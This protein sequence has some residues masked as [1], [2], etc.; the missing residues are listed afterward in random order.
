[1]TLWTRTVVVGVLAWTCALTVDWT[2]RL[3]AQG[4]TSPRIWQGVFSATQAARGKET[5]NTACVRCHGS[6]LGGTT[7]PALT[8]DRFQT[9]FGREPIEKLFLK[10]RDTMPPNFGTV[11]DDQAKL[12]IVTYIL[13][14]N[15]YPG[16]AA[17]LALGSEDLVG[18][19]VLR[20]GEQASV[21]NFS[22]VQTVGC[23]VRG[24][25]DTWM[26]QK[27]AEPAATRDD[28]PTPEGLAAAAGRRLGTRTFRLLSAGSFSPQVHEGRKME[29]RG[30]VY[31]E[32]ADS[33]LSL[34]SLQM[35][36]ASCDSE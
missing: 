28:V 10:I 23:L 6:E 24:P 33:R 26:L 18:A 27:T 25:N 17:E 21:Q 36:A 9:T 5:F 15:G 11:L 14:T 19:Q 3:D 34:T 20:Q 35:V 29:A 1:M 22:L 16:G 31:N 12:D 4:G 13:Q 8:G 2:A 32:S 7:A 30:L